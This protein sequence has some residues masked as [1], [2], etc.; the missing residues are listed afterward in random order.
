MAGGQFGEYQPAEEIYEYD[1]R[2]NEW[3]QIGTLPAPRQGGAV[4]PVG[5]MVVIA[6]GGSQTD[7]PHDEVWVGELR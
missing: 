7:V 1:I 6:L 2:Q 4:L 3:A 5:G